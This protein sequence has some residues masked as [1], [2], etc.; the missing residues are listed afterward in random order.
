MTQID[1]AHAAMEAAPQDD[2]LR[3]QFWGIVAETELFLMLADDAAGN[4][5]VPAEVT[6]D[7]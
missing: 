7:G 2:A 3:L 6:V 1:V 4:E 5:V